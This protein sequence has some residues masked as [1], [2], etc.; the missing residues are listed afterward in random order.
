M[1]P[2]IAGGQGHIEDAGSTSCA[3]GGFQQ[4]STKG[5]GS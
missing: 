2:E 3:I 5:K 4:T 1:S